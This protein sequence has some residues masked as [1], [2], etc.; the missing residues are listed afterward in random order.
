MHCIK[1]RLMLHKKK[2]YNTHTHTHFVSLSV[3]NQC[4]Q[5]PEDN[6]LSAVLAGSV[7]L[8]RHT[9]INCEK[10]AVDVFITNLFLQVQDILL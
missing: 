7:P 6:G 9:V 4:Q 2:L 1:H 10:L 8:L 3:N 5:T